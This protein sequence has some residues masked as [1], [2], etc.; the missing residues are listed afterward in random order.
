[1]R[2][3][4]RGIR[5]T[6]GTAP[7]KKAPA[8]VDKLLAMVPRPG[9]TLIEMRDRALLLFGFAGAF[10]RSE[11]VSLDVGDLAEATEGMRVT[12][13]RSKS[14]Q[15]GQGATIAIPRG[16]FAC[17]IEALTAWLAAAEITSGP[18]FRSIRKGGKVAERLSARAVA[19]IVKACA[20]RAGLDPAAFAG[21]SLR[22]GFI[23]SADA[24]GARLSKIMD[25]SRHKRIETVRGYTRDS[26]AFRD[27]AGVGLL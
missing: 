10:R 27:H 11:L 5:R 14:D 20:E 12:I 4:V 16:S 1:L 6:S 17:P 19:R 8:T 18:V 21:H 9:G 15:E 13:R 7:S 2:A 25:Q 24:R 22:A 23:T 26:E 3:T